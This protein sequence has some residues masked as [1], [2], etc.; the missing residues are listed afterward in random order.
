MIEIVLLKIYKRG[1]LERASSHMLADVS[2]RGVRVTKSGRQK[3]AR[4][5]TLLSR[6]G[7]KLYIQIS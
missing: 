3:G 5:F 2:R 4:T 7:F 1:T 6:S